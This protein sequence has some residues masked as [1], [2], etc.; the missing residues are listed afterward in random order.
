MI[1]T[2]AAGF[3]GA[4]LSRF[5]LGQG[6]SV[7]GLVKKSTS[8]WRINELL[9]TS[10][11]KLQYI[12]LIEGEAELLDWLQ[13]LKPD[14]IIHGAATGAYFH[15]TD[16][17]AIFATNAKWAAQ[18]LKA[19]HSLSS[20]KL[21]INLGSSSEYGEQAKVINESTL[22]HPANYY[23][24]SKSYLS[25]LGLHLA[26][27]EGFPFADAR[28][29]SVYGPFEA[30]TRLISTL[31]NCAIHGQKAHLHNPD[32]KRDFI[33]V[34][35]VCEALLK[36][37]LKPDSAKGQ[38]FNVATGVESSIKDV[39]QIVAGFNPDKPIDFQY[40]SPGVRHYKEPVKWQA[41]ISKIQELLDFT[42][43]LSLYQGL[44][45]TYEWFFQN[46]SLYL[47][48]KKL[49][50]KARE[51][52][53]MVL[54]MAQ[55]KGSSH[56]GSCFSCIDLL[57]Y[58]YFYK[59][60][61]VA[62]K[63]PQRDYFFLSKGHAAMALY[64]VLNLKGFISKDALD[65]Y[66]SDG[67]ILGAHPN[68]NLDLGIEMT[69]GS[70]GHGLP[71]AAGVAKALQDDKKNN[72]VYILLGEGDLGEGSSWESLLFIKQ[73]SL[74]NLT[75]IV[76]RNGLYSMDTTEKIASLENLE[77][78]FRSFGFQTSTF[79]GHSFTEI[80]EV[81]EVPAE[82]PRAL[83]AK[84]VKGYG[85]SFMENNPAW[86]FKSPNMQEYQQALEELRSRF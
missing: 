44:Q 39:S 20:L 21:F 80:H 41:D 58:L 8:L 82:A 64:T 9:D 27:E 59:M 25:L 36:M 60:K 81:M 19:A 17:K 84:T 14:F 68:R 73:H 78:K 6:A 24:W 29:F 30:A 75:V 69:S 66:M 18:L 10:R 49:R 76:D 51:V 11:F 26:K 31:M 33:H 13:E 65:S 22:P 15:Q 55:E 4:N 72:H 42:P 12:E 7:F 70:L 28:I 57:I 48:T 5:L 2:G 47:A 1:L 43:K 54:L 37:C 38:I 34:D 61:Q 45:V 71:Y 16:S 35:D 77:E 83:I 67:S 56:I 85:V 52:R 32:A 23:A 3:I 53:E 79:S 63:D 86:H 62:P 40:H 74:R 46:T 50:Q